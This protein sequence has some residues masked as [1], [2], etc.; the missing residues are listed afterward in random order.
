MKKNVHP[1]YHPVVFQ[2]SGTGSMFLTR[3]TVTSERTVEYS[4]GRTYPLVVVD[5]TNESHPFWTGAARVMDTQGRVEK[6]ERRYGTRT[7]KA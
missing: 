5:V 3:S 7:R 6:F 2:D 1:D 4:D